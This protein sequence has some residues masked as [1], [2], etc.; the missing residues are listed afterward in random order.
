MIYETKQTK[1]AAP[2]FKDWQESL[3]WSCLQGVMGTL[4]VDSPKRPAS[5]MI[6]LGDFCYLAGKPDSRFILHKPYPGMIMVPQDDAWGRL[7]ED[8][9]GGKIP[10]EI[11]KVTRY[12]IKKE[13]GVFDTKK[14]QAAAASLPEG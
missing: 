2:L 14:L 3:I 13:P 5:A 4:Y 1:K 7:I 12:A 11:K 6:I 8:C 10:Y 9:G